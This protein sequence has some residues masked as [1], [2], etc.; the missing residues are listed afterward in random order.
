MMRGFSTKQRYTYVTVFA[1]HYSDFTYTHLRR[2]TNMNDTLEAK[3]TFE[4]VFHRHGLTVL[5]YHADN[6]RFANKDFLREIVECKQKSVSVTL[7]P[8][9]KTEKSKNVF[10]TYKMMPNSSIAFCC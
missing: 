8:I 5:H 9:S 2:F 1:D 4:P 3:T 10:V 6:D 7:T